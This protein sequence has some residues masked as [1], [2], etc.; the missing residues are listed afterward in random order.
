MTGTS[1][2]TYTL[3]NPDG[4]IASQNTTQT[5]TVTYTGVGDPLAI[6]G[7][8]EQVQ[9][10]DSTGTLNPANTMPQDIVTSIEALA[11]KAS[12]SL[13]SGA[14]GFS[15]WVANETSAIGSTITTLLI[16]VVIGMGLFYLGPFIKRKLA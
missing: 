1:A 9:T 8:G 13:S 7:P 11:S 4:S 6:L 10:G 5:P 16:V 3:Y 12:S 2:T 15:N 14:S